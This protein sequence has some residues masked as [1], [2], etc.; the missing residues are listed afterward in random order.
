MNL[1]A[2]PA[3]I[4]GVKQLSD[5]AWSPTIVEGTLQFLRSS[6]IDAEIDFIRQL[7]SGVSSGNTSIH[8]AADRLLHLCTECET[9]LAKLYSLLQDRRLQWWFLR[10][11]MYDNA[12]EY[13]LR[14]VQSLHKALMR[15]TDMFFKCL[16]ASNYFI[17]S[18]TH[19]SHR[20]QASLVSSQESCEES[21]R[22][23]ETKGQKTIH[24]ELAQ[25]IGES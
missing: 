12:I 19:E 24:R 21:L 14:L 5:F 6:D 23:V 25:E 2:L 22:G 11:Y 18:S 4:T 1:S 15:R 9:Q 10:S 3:T 17:G 7:S 20:Q 13:Q 8:L 16:A